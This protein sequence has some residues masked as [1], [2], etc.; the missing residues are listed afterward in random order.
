M[1]VAKQIEPMVADKVTVTMPSQT[2]ATTTM[3][4]TEP[5]STADAVAKSKSDKHDALVRSLQ[6]G[7]LIEFRDQG[8]SMAWLK[9]A[10]IS[11]NGSIF[12][13][14]NKQGERALTI[15]AAALAERFRRDEAQ[16]A[17]DTTVGDGSMGRALGGRLQNVA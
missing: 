12:V 3:A 14:T 13:F 15:N 10:W 11:P 8:G 2:P 1:Q 7:T 17:L 16:I 6:R 9:L 5:S 4:I